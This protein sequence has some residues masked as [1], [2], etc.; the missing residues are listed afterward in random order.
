MQVKQLVI[1]VLTPL[2]SGAAT[3]GAI[4]LHH[5]GLNS[6]VGAGR[7]HAAAQSSP[8]PEALLSNWPQQCEVFK[9]ELLSQ[10]KLT[11]VTYEARPIQPFVTPAWKFNWQGETI[12]LPLV[13]YSDVRVVRNE[14]GK[15]FVILEDQAAEARV[16]LNQLKQSQPLVDVFAT[17]PHP[18]LSLAQL[19]GEPEGAAIALEPDGELGSEVDAG[20]KAIAVKRSHSS[21]D[22]PELLA[23]V[24]TLSWD[25]PGLT[26]RLFDGPVA[27]EQ[28]IDQGY[29]HR[30]QSL[31]CKA[32]AWEKELPIAMGL[33]LKLSTGNV[34][35]AAYANV[36]QRPGRLLL[37]R[38]DGR[39]IWQARFGEGEFYFDVTIALPSDHES[40]AV[41]MGMGQ[42]SW[43]DAEP[44]PEWLVALERA[45]E[46]DRLYAWQALSVE[47]YRAGMSDES[48][49]SI[50]ALTVE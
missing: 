34:P 10:P 27:L 7:V 14:D 33:A 5:H 32:D 40:A 50:Q 44:R 4:A 38:G 49:Q 46:V 47:L 31:S 37:H 16:M 43:W 35:E 36:G 39:T 26:E 13:N 17:V 29:R 48:A 23:P 25:G 30:P 41:G 2:I 9:Q 24:A 8:E 15:I 19:Q 12:A 6:I 42:E 20:V 28:L 11:K 21:L 45:L 22:K 1:A 3:F 18:A